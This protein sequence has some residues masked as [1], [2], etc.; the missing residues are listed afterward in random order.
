[1]NWKHSLCRAWFIS[2]AGFIIF[3]G[4]AEASEP[5]T[6]ATVIIS[7]G[8]GNY[9]QECPGIAFTG[10]DGHTRVVSADAYRCTRNGHAAFH[11]HDTL[12]ANKSEL[13][14]GGLFSGIL[15]MGDVYWEIPWAH[16]AYIYH[17]RLFVFYNAD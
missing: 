17:D 16:T 2:F 5:D 8:T 1:M 14:P 13:K 3:A 9:E 7:H 11:T 15:H 10:Q 12:Q 4:I 6:P